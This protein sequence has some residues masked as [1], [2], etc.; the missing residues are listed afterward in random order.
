[1]AG[2]EIVRVVWA[3]YREKDFMSGKKFSVRHG[4]SK[5]R[6]PAEPLIRFLERNGSLHT[7]SR[8][9]LRGWREDGMSVYQVDSWCIRFGTHPVMVYGDAFYEG[10]I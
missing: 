8:N 2:L 5:V 3:E 4:S 6:L 10:A 1:M 7:I 9:T